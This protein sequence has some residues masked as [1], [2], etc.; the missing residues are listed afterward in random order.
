MQS[1][2]SK[3]HK[4]LAA[5]FADGIG[6]DE[7]PKSVREIADV[8][9]IET[10]LYVIQHLPSVYDKKYKRHKLM[11]YVPNSMDAPRDKWLQF[12]IVHIGHTKTEVLIKNFG[13]E[14]LYPA[15]CS[16]L[17]SRQ[18]DRFIRDLLRE[19]DVSAVI[20]KIFDVQPK[21]VRSLTKPPEETKTNNAQYPEI[22][23]WQ[24]MNFF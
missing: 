15:N 1:S 5:F 2:K 14:I 3:L 17:I 20:G 4:K 8:I 9:G 21:Y 6:I 12:F 24:Q 18:R 11:M 7:L 13:G 10:T 19:K 23:N 16:H 22:A